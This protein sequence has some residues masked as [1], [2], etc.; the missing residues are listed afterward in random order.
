VG[1]LQEP[2]LLVKK[3]PLVR[4][5]M[6]RICCWRNRVACSDG[7]DEGLHPGGEGGLPRPSL[8]AQLVEKWQSR[9]PVSQVVRETCV[10]D[11]PIKEWLRAKVRLPRALVPLSGWPLWTKRGAVGLVSADLGGGDHHLCR[12]QHHDL[13]V[14]RVR[15]PVDARRPGKP[16]YAPPPAHESGPGS[17]GIT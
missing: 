8:Q 2:D 14:L 15:A 5:L 1:S 4:G 6:N 11:R 12:G 9:R 16:P 3:Q 13:R 10:P 7:Y 17:P